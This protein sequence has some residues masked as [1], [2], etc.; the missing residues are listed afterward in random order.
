ME[1]KMKF[2]YWLPRLLGLV[3]ILFI[4]LFALDAFS[5]EKSTFRQLFDFF[6]HM[7]PSLLLLIVLLI[8]WKK[9]LIGGILF[10]ILGLIATP[11]IFLH[12]YR[13]NQSIGMSLLVI[14]TITFP[15]IITGIIFIINYRRKK[16]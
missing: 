13:M 4:S 3:A 16:K 14:M 5:P 6:M 2:M 12:N 7:I 11:Y 1:K 8:A 9:E 15:F 10:L